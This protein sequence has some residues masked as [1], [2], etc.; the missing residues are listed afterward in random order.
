MIGIRRTVLGVVMV[1]DVVAKLGGATIATLGGVAV[2]TLGAVL[3]R[4]G[5]LGTRD[6]IADNC[7]IAARCLIFAL[8]VIGMVPP[9]FS[10]MSPAT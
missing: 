6:M 2:P 7:V 4:D 9:S 3:T 5:A 8:A 1:F 10:K